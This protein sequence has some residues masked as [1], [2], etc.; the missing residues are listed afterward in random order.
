[1]K[2]LRAIAKSLT[3]SLNRVYHKHE[4]VVGFSFF[5]TGILWDALTLRRIDNLVDN[6]ILIGYLVALTAVIL[7]DIRLK[8]RNLKIPRI[9][10]S[11]LFLRGVTQFL[12][13][14]LLSAYVIFYARSIAWATHFAFWIVL[15]LGLVVNE[16][17][18]RRLSSFTA[19]LLLL[20]FCSSTMLAYLL[21]VAAKFMSLGLFRS[22]VGISLIWCLAVFA[23]GFKAGRVKRRLFGPPEVW[24][25]VASGLL[26]DVG[27]RSNWIPPVPL[28]V[29]EGGV[30][31]LVVRD[32]DSFRVEWETRHR[33]FL[34][35]GYAKTFYRHQDEPI[36][37]FTSVFAPTSLEERLYHVWQRFDVVSGKWIST[38]RI[39]YQMTGGRQDG[40]RG[41]S[42]KR[43]V[44]EGKWR[45]LVET[46]D[47]RILTRIPFTIVD[48][49][50]EVVTWRKAELH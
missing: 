13:G 11:D 12:L 45:V 9:Q 46:E 49:Q 43:N 20:F 34:A 31:N 42:L 6:L 29:Q 4:R 17:L 16:F 2:G 36:Y 39:G 50:E 10:N 32:G 41:T 27:Y 44:M 23:V 33:G 15:V 48:R 18:T 22:A 38:D 26:L 5:V 8:T 21:P 37:C 35:P 3:G 7:L 14:A 28:S 30:Y 1:M 40:Y 19:Q 24:A 25:L 47:H